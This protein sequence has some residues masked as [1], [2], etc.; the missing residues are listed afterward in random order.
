MLLADQA[1]LDGAEAEP[2]V[3]PGPRDTQQPGLRELAPQL[4]VEGF[5]GHL[6]R[7]DLLRLAAAGEDLRRESGEVA[8]RLVEGEVHRARRAI[9]SSVDATISRWISFTPPP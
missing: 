9:F 5:V 8:L 3:R 4:A 6:D 1:E 7:L 2:A